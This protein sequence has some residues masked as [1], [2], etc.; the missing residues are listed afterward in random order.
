MYPNV[1]CVSRHNNQKILFSED[2]LSVQ[3]RNGGVLDAVAGDAVSGF[4][5]PR[6]PNRMFSAEDGEVTGGQ[7][8]GRILQQTLMSPPACF[9]MAEILLTANTRMAEFATIHD[10]SLDRPDDLPA[11]DVAAAR[12]TSGAVEVIQLGDCFAVW[13]LRSGEINTTKNQA[14][15]F[16]RRLRPYR[17]MYS[18]GKFWV[19][20]EQ[21][22]RQCRIDLTNKPSSQG[23]YATLN[24]QPEVAQCW[25]RTMLA[26]KDVVLLL[27]FTD[28]LV[29]PEH[30][31]NSEALGQH[32]VF[33]YKQGGWNAILASIGGPDNINEGTGIALEF[34]S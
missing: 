28:G 7:A 19:R 26:Y 5:S 3:Y 18:G 29:L 20:A 23:G 32:M 14:A 10:I 22:F 4:H 12:I 6:V 33:T 15:E 21:V 8:V 27:L 16:E 17:S 25:Y 34:L 24:G 11:I 30:L 9:S 1:M 13:Q 31:F 2:V